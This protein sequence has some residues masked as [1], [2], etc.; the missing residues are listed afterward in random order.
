MASQLRGYSGALVRIGNGAAGQVQLD[1]LGEAAR[2][3]GEL[4]RVHHRPHELLGRVSD[5]AEAAVRHWPLPDHGIWEV[6]GD[7][8][9][10]VHSKVMA[11]SALR[12][13]SELADRGRI[14]G[15]VAS[16][17]DASAA[18]QRAV[19]S[20][21]QGPDGELG[22]S[23]PEPEAG[24]SL[25]AAYLVSF[26]SPDQVGA[27]PT[28]RRI[29]RDLSRGLRRARHW[30]ERDGIDFPCFPSIFP[31]LGAAAAEARHLPTGRP[32]GRR[33]LGQL[34]PGAEPGGPDGGSARQLAPRAPRGEPGSPL[35]AHILSVG[36]AGT[37]LSTL[38][39]FV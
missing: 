11:W 28:L 25:L 2:L 5:L 8:Q 31:G 20:H 12:T 23:F 14:E 24:S 15:S 17:R 39:P 10:Y 16:W 32:R 4:D 1:A 37:A 19:L 22:M 6:R 21:G 26:I 18:I 38:A 34:P 33:P 3:A 36:G 27:E 7:P 9:D 35:I 30:P 29:S 13:A